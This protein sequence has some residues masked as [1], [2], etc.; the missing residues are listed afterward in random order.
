MSSLSIADSSR[1]ADIDA[2]MAEQGEASDEPTIQHSS[3]APRI[4]LNE[5]V[6]PTPAV[7]QFTPAQK[8]ERIKELCATPLAAGQT[9]YLVSKR[10]HRR[11][12]RACT[13]AADKEGVVEEKDIGSVDNSSLVDLQGNIVSSISEGVDMEYVS[14]EAWNLLV[15]W[16]V[17]GFLVWLICACNY[18]GDGGLQES[19]TFAL[20]TFIPGMDLL[21]GH[22][23]GKL[24][25]EAGFK[26]LR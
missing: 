14:E 2:Y 25:R 22:F 7:A 5:G 23:L 20:T 24:L 19:L 21:F 10:W 6:P 13:G 1:D 8:F 3:I 15:S 9:W 18:M 11:W 16:C 17:S 4:T 26:N 12:E